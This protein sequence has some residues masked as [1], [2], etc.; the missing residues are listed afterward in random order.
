LREAYPESSVFSTDDSPEDGVAR[1]DPPSQAGDD[2]DLATYAAICAA[3]VRTGAG[4]TRRV[5][6]V[7]AARGL[8][9]ERWADI[10]T[11]WIER[12]RR[13]PETRA[14][15]RRHYAQIE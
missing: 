11:G 8:T 6:E 5:E 4:S 14:A 12:I 9:P 10:E 1:P 2:L 7:L 15:F 13:D 3:L